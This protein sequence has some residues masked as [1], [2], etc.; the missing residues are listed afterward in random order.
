MKGNYVIEGC[1]N[2]YTKVEGTYASVAPQRG[3]ATIIVDISKTENQALL[4]VGGTLALGP[5]DVDWNGILLY[6]ESATTVKAYSRECTHQQCTIDPFVGG[7]SAC[8]CHRSR[9]NLS[10]EKISGPASRA[11]YQYTASIN[12]NIIAIDS[13][14]G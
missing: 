3:G 14:S 11:L 1:A 7:V 8:P 9:F 13:Q 4:A 2:L 10:G 5:N 12:G 6:R